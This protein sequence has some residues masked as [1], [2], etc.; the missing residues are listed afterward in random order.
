MSFYTRA[1]FDTDDPY[2]ACYYNVT[3]HPLYHKC[4]AC[5]S[6]HKC[7]LPYSQIST[8]ANLNDA[9]PCKGECDCKNCFELCLFRKPTAPKQVPDGWK[10]SKSDF[11]DRIIEWG[12]NHGGYKPEDV[13][14]DSTLKHY[15][16]R[17]WTFKRWLKYH[18]GI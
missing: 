5:P 11:E 9:L 14:W 7:T 12:L 18:F 3:T 2:W 16:R 4:D 1:F 17:E 10:A 13:Y 8:L 15:V 6:F